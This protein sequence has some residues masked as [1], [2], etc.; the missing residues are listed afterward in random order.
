LGRDDIKD[1]IV[2]N[3]GQV[4]GSVSK[5]TSYILAGQ[6]PGSKIEKAQELKIPILDWDEFQK[7]FES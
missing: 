1:L 6:E 4:S 5:K 3:G 2:Q 7:M